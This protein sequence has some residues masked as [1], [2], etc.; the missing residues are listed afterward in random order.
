M[1][2][3]KE[4]QIVQVGK[5]RFKCS[6]RADCT[7]KTDSGRC[8]RVPMP[9]AVDRGYHYYNQKVASERYPKLVDLH[10]CPYRGS[11]VF[12]NDHTR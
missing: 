1:A 6:K 8:T 12:K 7:Y 4:V 9:I 3:R 5:R 2:K 11:E 10:W